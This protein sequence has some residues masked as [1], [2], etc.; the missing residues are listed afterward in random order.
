MCKK[1]YNMYFQHPDNSK[2][3]LSSAQ[4]LYMHIKAH[5]LESYM[6]TQL[7]CMRMH[8]LQMIYYHACVKLESF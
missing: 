4:I 2:T 6:W 3:D 1:L 8:F 5:L 7:K